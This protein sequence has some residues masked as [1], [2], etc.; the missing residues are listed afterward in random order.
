MKGNPK[1]QWRINLIKQIDEKLN[2]IG[3]VRII[4]LTLFDRV[5]PNSFFFCIFNFDF[6]ICW[7]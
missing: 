7:C 4:T 6:C 3:T 5:I 1:V 2:D